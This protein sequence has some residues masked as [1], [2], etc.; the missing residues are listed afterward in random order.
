MKA[1]RYTAV[2]PRPFPQTA[3]PQKGN[4]SKQHIRHD[5]KTPSV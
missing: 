2:Q 4:I 5:E 3:I 1:F